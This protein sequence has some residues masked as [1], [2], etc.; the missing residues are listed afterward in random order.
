MYIECRNSILT[1]KPINVL[2]KKP[3]IVLSP[4]LGSATATL[5]PRRTTLESS[6]I[7][8]FTMPSILHISSPQHLSNQWSIA[9]TRLSRHLLIRPVVLTQL[10]V[11]V[12]K[13]SRRPG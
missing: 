10:S 6:P 7:A 13:K 3:I 5:S 1:K 2:M 11:E 8:Y 9:T 12:K 4:S